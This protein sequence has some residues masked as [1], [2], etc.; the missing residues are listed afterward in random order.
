MK[1]NEMADTTDTNI[2]YEAPRNYRLPVMLLDA[3]TKV[4]CIDREADDL[5][6]M[7]D[8]GCT[9]NNG[10]SCL[11]KVFKGEFDPDYTQSQ[12]YACDLTWYLG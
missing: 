1:E 8:K 12:S 11:V 6:F 5:E 10:C 7:C 3:F 9:F 4:W 2:K